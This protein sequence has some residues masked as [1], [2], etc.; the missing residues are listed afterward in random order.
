[1]KKDNIVN[2]SKLKKIMTRIDEYKPL[3]ESQEIIN[4][5]VVYIQE[6]EGVCVDILGYEPSIEIIGMLDIGKDIVKE[7]IV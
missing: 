2:F 6:E 7:M 4:V 5:C 1:M 3:I